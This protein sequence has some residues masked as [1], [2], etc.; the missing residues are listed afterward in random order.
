MCVYVWV[1]GCSLQHLQKY[2]KWPASLK[3]S[4]LGVRSSKKHQHCKQKDRAVWCL[5]QQ[6]RSRTLIPACRMASAPTAGQRRALKIGA[7]HM[8]QLLRQDIETCVHHS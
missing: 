2:G 4:L 7:R 6:Q 5:R 1:G 8:S 3:F